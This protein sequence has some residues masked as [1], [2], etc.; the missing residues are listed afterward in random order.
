MSDSEHCEKKSF[1]PIKVKG[2]VI[3]PWL[4]RNTLRMKYSKCVK[5]SVNIPLIPIYISLTLL[6]VLLDSRCVCVCVGGGRESLIWRI[7]VWAVRAEFWGGEVNKMATTWVARVTRRV[8]EFNWYPAEAEGIFI[9][10]EDGC[11]ERKSN[12]ANGDEIHVDL[13]WD[14]V[15]GVN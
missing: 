1:M 7:N 9:L 5:S 4:L 2:D 12:L 6:S 14:P 8:R 13:R 15:R 3:N 11:T 10:T